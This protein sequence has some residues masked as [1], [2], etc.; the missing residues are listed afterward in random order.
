MELGVFL[1]G[2]V[3]SSVTTQERQCL[4]VNQ[5]PGDADSLTLFPLRGGVCFPLP[6][7]WTCL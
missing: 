2:K 4:M 7:T 1:V 5:H 6:P 3:T